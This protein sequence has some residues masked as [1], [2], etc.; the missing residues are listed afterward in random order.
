MQAAEPIKRVRCTSGFSLTVL[1]LIAGCASTTPQ[2][3]QT[4]GDSLN[5]A[6]SAQKIQSPAVKK[7]ALPNAVEFERALN[8]H[9]GQDTA[10]PASTSTST[11]S[12]R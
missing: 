2:L 12:Q 10:S 5:K 6:T 4:F 11:P 7:Q 1:A 9:L 3:D 8:N